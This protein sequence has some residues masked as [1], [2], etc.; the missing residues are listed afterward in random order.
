[1]TKTNRSNS[2]RSRIDSDPAIAPSEPF[3]ENATSPSS[4]SS[5]V[6][7]N[8]CPRGPMT[9]LIALRIT[10]RRVQRSTHSLET[11]LL[12]I[13]SRTAPLKHRFAAREFAVSNRASRC[14]P[15]RSHSNTSTKSS[16]RAYSHLWPTALPIQRTITLVSPYAFHSCSGSSACSTLYKLS[17]V[18]SRSRFSRGRANQTRAPEPATLRRQ[19]AAIGFFERSEHKGS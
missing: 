14:K 12:V 10:T 17:E 4:V 6:L 8:D 13:H 19:D 18:G 2:G 9:R 3:G 11:E 7:T 15:T 1:M 16:L 5:F